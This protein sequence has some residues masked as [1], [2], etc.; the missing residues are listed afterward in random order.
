MRVRL[1]DIPSDAD[2]FGALDFDDDSGVGIRF[3]DLL[4]KPVRAT[5]EDGRKIRI[6]RR[7][8]KLTLAIGDAKGEGLLRRLEHGP[9]KAQMFREAMRE[10]AEALGVR[11]VEA[12]GAL[13]LEI[14]E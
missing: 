2:V 1:A 3:V 11:Y 10:A 8:L 7:G 13:F 5:L 4:L 9:D 12:D 6:K 14:G